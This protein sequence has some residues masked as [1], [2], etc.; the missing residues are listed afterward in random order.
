MR[1][2]DANSGIGVTFLSDYPASD[3]YYRLRRGN[4]GALKSFHLDQHP[5]SQQT[6]S[7]T[8]DTGVVPAADQ[9]IR[10]RVHLGDVGGRTEIRASVWPDGTPEPP[11]WQ[12]DAYDDDPARLT[13][14]T[15]G[16]WSLTAGSKYWDDLR[17]VHLAP[18]LDS[19]SDSV[20]DETDNCP[21]V[22]NQ[23]QTDTDLDGYG[24]PC[25]G[26]FDDD[27]DGDVDLADFAAFRACL[28]G[29]TVKTWT[30]TTPPRCKPPCR[31]VLPD[32]PP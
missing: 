10:F 21:T 31:P 25:D 14:G 29:P 11:D 12:I 23:S 13:T 5:D 32:Q 15:I 3:T 28:L 19:D 18:V 7:G 2:T 20:C 8:T 16:V 6:L 4:F 9:W 1:M 24:D 26:P 27:H 17:V 30:C 22:A